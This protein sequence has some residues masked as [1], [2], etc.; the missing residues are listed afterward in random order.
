MRVRILPYRTGSAS[1]R[2]LS[3]RL[4]VP[5]INLVRT[6]FRARDGDL[7]LNWGEHNT[8]PHGTLAMGTVQWLNPLHRVAMARDKLTAFRMM[9]ALDVPTVEWTQDPAV[10]L[11]WC[12]EDSAKHGNGMP[13]IA[14]FART[15][16]T[17]Q[18][19]AGIVPIMSGTEYSIE[20]YAWPAAPLYTRYWKAKHE[21]RVHVICGEAYAQ[22]KRRRNVVEP[23]VIRNHR[24]GYVFCTQNVS[25][26]DLV[27]QTARDAIN[28]IGLH[29]GAVDILCNKAETEARVL[30]IN[31][32]PG[33]EG[34]TLDF[35]VSKLRGIINDDS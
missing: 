19:G 2:A 22:K 6:R 13:R 7:I 33:L 24:N 18:G 15:T 32:A 28:S 3:Q 25:P 10:A 26:P 23:S 31:T 4:G 17:G 21:Y 20:G 27:M 16:T 9:K 14:G 12:N 11:G 30:E 1:A 29:F 5:R 34:T 8:I 35:Y